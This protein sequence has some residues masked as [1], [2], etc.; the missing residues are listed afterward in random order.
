MSGLVSD[1]SLGEIVRLSDRAERIEIDGTGLTMKR[2][3]R[4]VG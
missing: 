1:L 2:D 3:Q 4:K